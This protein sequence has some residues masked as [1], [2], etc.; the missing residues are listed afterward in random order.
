MIEE[1]SNAYSNQ[2][3]ILLAHCKR[4][5]QEALGIKIRLARLFQIEADAITANGHNGTYSFHI[6]G[7]YTTS[8]GNEYCATSQEFAATASTIIDSAVIQDTSGRALLDYTR[9]TILKMTDGQPTAAPLSLFYANFYDNTAHAMNDSFGIGRLYYCVHKELSV[10][11]NNIAAIAV[12]RNIPTKSDRKYWESYYTTGGA[13]GDNTYVHGIKRAPG[14]TL[15][16]MTSLGLKIRFP[17][18][19][20]SVISSSR[21]RAAQYGNAIDSALKLISTAKPLL[22]NSL[23]VGLSGGRDSR[24][25]TALA[26][27]SDLDFQSFTAVPPDLEADIAEQLHDKSRKHF[28]WER[29]DNRLK[30]KS[31]KP[32]TQ[33]SPI[34]ERAADWFEF[35][36]G[37]N[38]PTF[39]RK[40]SPRRKP[41]PVRSMALSG[42]FGDF[43]RGH[44][45]TKNEVIS[46]DPETAINRMQSSFLKM[47]HLAPAEIRES[48]VD[49]FKATFDEMADHGI[50]G[51]YALDG[52]FLVNRMRRQFPHPGPNTLIPMLSTSMVAD[53]FW[54]DPASKLNG[55]ALREMT[56]KLVPEWSSVPYFHEAAVGSDPAVT[57]KVTI[58]PTYWEV[59]RDDFLASVEYSVK[60]NDFFDLSTAAVEQAIVDLPGG[61]TRTNSFFE[62]VFWHAGFNSLLDRINTVVSD[63]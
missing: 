27:Q 25:V 52:S 61:R 53:V 9:N 41:I 54:D 46:R 19:L 11:S 18:S 59:D 16:K 40:N 39:M 6:P 10:V 28:R 58:Q 26:L 37:D 21:D 15:V 22:Q 29:R 4:G 57:N 44:Y 45:Y 47:R 20:Y 49:Q 13:V 14:G 33:L 35:T 12:A 24:F 31:G 50:T 5:D 32:P 2:P 62:T 34:L 43:A 48:G 60:K 3:V 56:N 17:T 36:G 23:S 42:A 8:F 63:G 55:D 38:W 7:S 51:F 30:A 1:L